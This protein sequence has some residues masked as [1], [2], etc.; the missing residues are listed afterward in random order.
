[1]HVCCAVLLRTVRRNFPFT[2]G[3]YLERTICRLGSAELLSIIKATQ[4]IP[5]G[6]LSCSVRFVLDN[7]NPDSRCGKYCLLN[8]ASLWVMA[9]NI[10]EMPI[11]VLMSSRRYELISQLT[12]VGIY[13]LES[14]SCWRF[15]TIWRQLHE[16]PHVLP[17][18]TDP[19][20]FVIRLG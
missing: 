20:A 5:N 1:M 19:L 13:L 4:T 18:C 14:L 7:S 9:E 12:I 17:S 11:C 10:E 2:T 16:E 8:S 15:C 6:Q 3:W